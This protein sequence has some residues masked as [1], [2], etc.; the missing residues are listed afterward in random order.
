MPGYGAEAGPAP[1]PRLA[2]GGLA[3]PAPPLARHC[4]DIFDGLL[5]VIYTSST[6]CRSTVRAT[7]TGVGRGGGGRALPPPPQCMQVKRSVAYTP[8]TVEITTLYVGS[9]SRS[10]TTTRIY[11]GSFSRS[12]TTTRIYVGSFSR[13]HVVLLYRSLT[14]QDV[15]PDSYH[16]L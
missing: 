13:S 11:V 8:H 15:F 3:P 4:M 10:H 6:M 12:H 7:S 1:P 2:P 14:S 16:L 5:V 9:F